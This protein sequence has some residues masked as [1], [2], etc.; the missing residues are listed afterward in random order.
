MFSNPRNLES[1]NAENALLAFFQSQRS[2]SHAVN[3][4]LHTIFDKDDVY[5]FRN[6]ENFVHWRDQNSELLADYRVYS[7]FS[8]FKP[9]DLGG[10]P[11][12]AFASVRHPVHRLISL[13]GMSKREES[14][15][16][17][18]LAMENDIEGYYRKGSEERPYYFRNL[19][20]QRVSGT[21]SFD[22]AQEMMERFFGAVA[23]IDELNP[24]TKLL[25][26]TY[27][28]GTDPVEAKSM[29]A[30]QHPE[31]LN[32][33]FAEQILEENSADLALFEFVAGFDRGKAL[34]DCKLELA[35]LAKTEMEAEAHTESTARAK[36]EAK[37]E[38][39]AAARAKA[40]AKAETEAAARAKAEAKAETE[41]AARA[42]AEAKAEA[43]A[44]ARTKA[45]AKAETEAAARAKAE[46]KVRAENK[47]KAAAAAR[48]EADA[49]ARAIARE[50]ATCQPCPICGDPMKSLKKGDYCP[51][52]NMPARG[53]SLVPLID[54]ILNP[55]V[56]TEGATDLPI[57]AFAATSA[58]KNVLAR[59]WPMIKSVSLY[60][61]YGRDHEEGVDVRA[62]A[63]YADGSFSAAMGIL[64]FDYFPEH[65][66]AL[67]ELY[68][69][70]APGSVMFTLI[71]SGR[72]L[73]GYAPPIVTKRIE[74][75]PG[76][77]DY[78]PEGG[79]LSSVKVGQDWLLDAIA[80]AGFVPQ[81][82][83]LFDEA[84][85]HTL[86]WFIGYKPKTTPRLPVQKRG[87]PTEVAAEPLRDS[88]ASGAETEA[89]GKTAI[90]PAATRNGID[91]IEGFRREYRRDVDP[92]FGFSSI[93]LTLTIPSVPAAGRLASFAEHI[94]GTGT[95][96]GTMPG[97]V[98]VSE[99]MGE[100]W[101]AITFP[102]VPDVEFENCFTTRSGI[103]LLQTKTDD[104]FDGK[105]GTPSV[106][107]RFAPDWSYLD[108]VPIGD[109]RWHGTSSIGQH[110]DTIIWAEYP[111]NAGN[112]TPGKEDQAISPRV[113]RSR[114]EG[115]TWET[116]FSQ[117]GE[118]IRHFHTLLADPHVPGQWWLSSGDRPHECRVWLS[119]DDGDNWIDI[120]NIKPDVD[121]NAQAY[122][123][124]VQRYTDLWLDKDR[125]IWGSDD[126]LGSPRNAMLS[127]APDIGNQ[128]RSGSRMFVSDRVV[129]LQPRNLGWVG[130][131]VRSIIDVGPALIATTEAKYDV[132]TRPQICLVAKDGRPLV[133]E[134]LAVDVAEDEKSGFTYSRSSHAAVNGT[135]FTFRSSRDLGQY[136]TRILQWHVEFD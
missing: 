64:L 20:T 49:R 71:L 45:E 62:M 82:A 28:I 90:I 94:A 57:L 119:R 26:D 84:S 22:A 89:E 78:I 70:L 79:E 15:V 98:L 107:H 113:F 30:E 53:R 19:C 29:D 21:D 93:K 58:E 24:F 128:R 41:A 124:S 115:A 77:F 97:G 48:A 114:D 25:S 80:R 31:L 73:P 96:V 81:Q 36:A 136:A 42:K 33:P 110:G 125:V 63:G 66:A 14:H 87:D 46:A 10:R 68:R 54:E 59:I 75:K 92:A 109:H 116:V 130:N 126:W 34:T 12:V 106:I 23:T 86:E 17:H 134:L 2:G 105:P 132:L 50:K 3:R 103:H 44:A 101:R 95:V 111:H 127:D 35:I 16:Y 123:Q 1:G 6:V 61:S 39:E 7:G 60:G 72:V 5:F 47:E 4:W 69:V 129:P 74:P 99:D 131:P 18:Q 102:E 11:F 108:A 27:G 65:E 32:S 40:E 37:A 118:N 135:F 120:T 88:I 52:C 76:Y 91:Y 56:Q 104:A 51:G 121:L 100:N 112:H 85:G 117:S 83:R 122:P 67:A 8:D 13:Y 43:E 133:Q 38:T 9:I 55:W